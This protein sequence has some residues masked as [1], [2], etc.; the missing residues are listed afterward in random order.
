MYVLASSF[1]VS[2]ATG[3]LHVLAL[4]CFLIAAVVAYFV[5]PVHRIA[6]SLIAAGLVFFTLATLWS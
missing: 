4:L 1:T 5:N 6:V 2:G 3:I